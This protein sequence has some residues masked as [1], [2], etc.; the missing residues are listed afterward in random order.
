MRHTQI[1]NCVHS[2]EACTPPPILSLSLHV[3]AQLR[4]R[5]ALEAEGAAVALPA[6]VAE[7]RVVEISD[8]LLGQLDAAR[9]GPGE[10]SRE[11]HAV[12]EDGGVLHD[13]VAG[14]G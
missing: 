1:Y 10:R 4:R 5:S 14:V 7:R 2:F 6:T 12:G 11:F 8:G 13:E 3:R 9:V